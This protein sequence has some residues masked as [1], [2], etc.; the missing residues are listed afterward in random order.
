MFLTRRGIPQFHYS[1]T[2][3]HHSV[4]SQSN[5][6]LHHHLHRPL[7]SPSVVVN[8]EPNGRAMKFK[9]SSA[10]CMMSF[11]IDEPIPGIDIDVLRQ[12][13]PEIA[14]DIDVL[15]IGPKRHAP[16]LR[17]NAESGLLRRRVA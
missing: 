8:A 17:S 7:P 12:P 4:R 3:T 1:P 9:L 15:P 11:T 13:E 5:T 14:C 6:Q 2:H 10:R 16:C